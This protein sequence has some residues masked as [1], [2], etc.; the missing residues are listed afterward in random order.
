[1]RVLILVD[2]YLPSSKSGAMLV[3]EL[4]VEFRRQGHEVTILTPS[5]TIPKAFHVSTEDGLRI[6][7][8]KSGRIKGT[9]KVSEAAS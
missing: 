4:G 6:V 2:C 9:A 3:H 1:M 7:R 5:D 8:V